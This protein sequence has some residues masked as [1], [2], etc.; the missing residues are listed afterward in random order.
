MFRARRR[1][2]RLLALFAVAGLFVAACGSDDDSTSDTT[3]G[4]GG[5]GDVAEY[6]IAYVGPLTGDAA[7]LGIYIRD[8]AKVAVDEFNKANSDIK[9]TMEEFDTQ[10]DPA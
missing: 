10:G 7:N 9:I 8:G 5:G 1:S 4:D 6:S 3:E 2:M